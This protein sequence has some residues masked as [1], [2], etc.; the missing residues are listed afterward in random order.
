MKLSRLTPVL[1]IVWLLYFVIGNHILPVTDP[2]ESNYALTAKEMVLSGDWLSPQIYGIYWFDKPIMIYWLLAFCYKLFGF[3]D[4]VPRLPSAIF[5]ALSVSM[6]YQ[7]MRHISGRWMVG[8]LGASI[9]GT[10][11]MF[12]TVAHGIITDMVLLY[13]TIMVMAYAYIGLTENSSKSM[14]IAYIFSGLG[15]LTKGPV[16]LV[17][18]GIILF[19]FSLLHRSQHIFARLFDWRGILAF[20]VVVLPWYGYMYSTHGQDFIDGFLGLHN[21]TRATQSE[22]PEDNVWWYYLPIFLGSSLPW[23]GAV[24]YGIIAGFKEKRTYYIYNMCWGVGTLLFY[25]LMATKYPL[26]TFISVVPFSVIGTIGVVKAIAPNRPRYIWWIVIGPTLLLWIAFVGATFVAPWG[27]YGLLYVFAAIAVVAL[28][29]FGWQRKGYSLLATIVIGTIFISSVVVVEGLSHLVRQRSSVEILPIIERFDGDIYYF[30]GY[31]ASAVYYT[32]KNIVKINGN[33][34]DDKRR[35]EEWDKK[36]L[37]EQV[38][39]DE[40]VKKLSE[41]KVKMI[42]VPKGELKRFNNSS[43]APYANVYSEVGRTTIY[44]LNPVVTQ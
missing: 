18:P 10:S 14:V 39:E 26:Y 40:F 31:S 28:L 36:Y 9:L 33:E 4:W 27:Y 24:I 15:V 7:A 42:I 12:W 44:V 21:V 11:L 17:L 20:L 1:F 8:L 13:T 41:G 35:S 19:V 22:H 38:A 30:N 6:L 3:A 29:W 23:T 16:A 37:M 43:I 2:V 32:G 25:T 34:K 5:G